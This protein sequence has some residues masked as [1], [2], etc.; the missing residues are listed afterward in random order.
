[1]VSLFEDDPDHT[2]K[3][4]IDH[5]TDGYYKCTLLIDGKENERMTKKKIIDSLSYL[6]DKWNGF[7]PRPSEN[8]LFALIRSNYVAVYGGYLR[9]VFCHREP[10]DLDLI[11]ERAY[12]RTFLQNL[13]Q[14]GYK[15]TER[16]SDMYFLKHETCLPIDICV[17]KEFTHIDVLLSPCSIPDVDVNDLCYSW[18]DS[19]KRYIIYRWADDYADAFT[20]FDIIE[21]LRREELVTYAH[22]EA[23][24]ERIQKMKSKG[25]TVIQ[26]ETIE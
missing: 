13:K 20:C 11:V 4:K 15:V 5:T 12:R 7:I 23:S 9:D 24:R 10:K 17:D 21:R 8:E 22:P 6:G 1:M 26:C 2:Y 16:K 14:I 19:K 3:I 25:F 18:S